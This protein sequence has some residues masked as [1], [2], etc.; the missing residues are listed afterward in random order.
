[1]FQHHAHH[2]Q[3]A[4]LDGRPVWEPP[5]LCYDHLIG[6]EYEKKRESGLKY[7]NHN[8]VATT[9]IMDVDA[10]R[11]LLAMYQEYLTIHTTQIPSGDA[12]EN[13]KVAVFYSDLWL[14]IMEDF[15][16]VAHGW[17]EL[18]V[19]QVKIRGSRRSGNQC[20]TRTQRMRA[21]IVIWQMGRLTMARGSVVHQLRVSFC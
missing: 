8:A 17:A 12:W 3:K 19:L 9:R 18:K 6:E 4:N 2:Y 13:F 5:I 7:R 10:E 16:H 15:A 20:L 1:M 21:K 11:K 14:E